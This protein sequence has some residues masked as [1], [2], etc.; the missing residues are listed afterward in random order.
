MHILLHLKVNTPEVSP[1]QYQALN[2]C[3]SG[4]NSIHTEAAGQGG[5]SWQ[6]RARGTA[7]EFTSGHAMQSSLLVFIIFMCIRYFRLILILCEGHL[8]VAR[9][10]K[11]KQA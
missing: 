3:A 5:Y 11:T 2:P 9:G 10:D 8:L 6:G 1:P 4:C 7:G